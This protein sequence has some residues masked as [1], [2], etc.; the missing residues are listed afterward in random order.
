MHRCTDGFCSVHH[1]SDT[2][3][4]FYDTLKPDLV[5]NIVILEDNQE[6]LLF[7]TSVSYHAVTEE[8]YYGINLS[9]TKLIGNAGFSEPVYFGII[10]NSPRTD[11][12]VD[13]LKYL[14][15]HE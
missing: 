12:A 15:N 1:L 10:A 4:D 13:Y 7:D 14:Y 11:N 8:H 3:S 2:D 6:D 9:R 5:A